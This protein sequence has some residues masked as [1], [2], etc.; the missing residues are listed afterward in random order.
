MAGFFSYGGYGSDPAS[1]HVFHSTTCRWAAFKK[2]P[3]INYRLELKE[4]R[5]TL[6]N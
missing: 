2:H 6:K 1:D 5:R 4:K 3:T